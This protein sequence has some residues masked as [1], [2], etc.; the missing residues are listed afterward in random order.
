MWKIEHRRFAAAVTALGFAACDPAP[1]PT[2]EPRAPEAAE[3]ESVEQPDREVFVDPAQAAATR[4]LEEAMREPDPYARASRLALLLQGLGPEGVPGAKELLQHPRFSSDRGGAEIELLGRYWA[5]HEPAAAALWAVQSS[6]AG[7]RLSAIRATLSQWASMDP[8]SA[9]VG[10]R[11]WE[12]SQPEARELIQIALVHG[13]FEHDPVALARYIEQQEKGI[14]RQR[15]LT[16]YTGLLVQRK[17]AEAAMRWAESIS[18]DDPI[19]KRRAYWKLGAALVSSDLDA[20]LRWCKAHCEGE[21]GRDLPGAISLRWSR[22][23]PSGAAL[24]WLGGR[25]DDPER[26]RAI[27]TAFGWWAKA[28]PEET[29]VWMERKW[30]AGTL[31]PWVQPLVRAYAVNA[32]EKTP[33]EGMMWVAR[34]EDEAERESLMIG[35]ARQWRAKDRAAAEAWLVE[36][37]LS[38]ESR[39]RA[40]GRKVTGNAAQASDEADAVEPPDAPGTPPS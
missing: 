2:D 24:D 10:L 36:S 7:Y 34:V 9:E 16:H 5:T 23:D 39:E 13:W 20:A 26:S 28:N 25:P 21:Y 15:M 19:Y 1:S 37:P 4:A 31:E 38:E 40:R 33:L 6:V 18:D 22:L 11:A 32:M 27:Q 35:L 17:G 29:R 30:A 8:E 14:G 12:I 3:S